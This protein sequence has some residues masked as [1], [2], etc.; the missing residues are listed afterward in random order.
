MKNNSGTVLSP[1]S[2]I[3]SGLRVALTIPDYGTLYFSDDD[4]A[5]SR[6]PAY[7]FAAL[8]K[9]LSVAPTSSDL[10]ATS[11]NMS[12]SITGIPDSSIT[13]ILGLKIKGST[14]NIERLVE[15]PNIEVRFAGIGSFGLTANRFTGLVTNYSIEE[16]W[17]MGAMKSTNKIVFTCSSTVDVLLNKVSGRRTNPADIPDPSMDRV[18]K[19]ANSNFNFGAVIR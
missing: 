19:L 18:L 2:A 10:R 5:A 8:G 7:R 14:I 9:L 1:K 13:E 12:V 16:D 4:R 17:P 11:G 15:A 6:S 3:Y